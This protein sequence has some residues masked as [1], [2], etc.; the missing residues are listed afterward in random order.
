MFKYQDPV[1]KTNWTLFSSFIELLKGDANLPQA[2]M[3]F[4]VSGLKVWD[5]SWSPKS[6]TYCRQPA[7][8]LQSFVVSTINY[9]KDIP[10][11]IPSMK[12]PQIL[13][14]RVHSSLFS[15]GHLSTREAWGEP[16]VRLCPSGTAGSFSVVFHS[17]NFFLHLFP[18][19]IVSAADLT[20]LF[21]SPF[22]GL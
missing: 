10:P 7:V 12:V 4:N 14:F 22:S 3:S 17:S 15:L 5:F 20:S 9:D 2:C 8:V 16:L 13:W 18:V 6:K 1:L 19:N 11:V 21:L